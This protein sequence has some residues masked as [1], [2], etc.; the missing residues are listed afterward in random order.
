MLSISSKSKYGIM[1]VLTLADHY[2]QGLMQIK[3]ISSLNNIPHQYLIQ[4]FNILGKADI[5]KSVRGKNGGY[6]LSRNPAD[7]SVLEIVELL[8]GEI[9][10]IQNN[11]LTS[12]VH[13]LLHQAELS[14]K[15]VLNV[16]FADLLSSQHAIDRVPMFDI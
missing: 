5:I 10:F 15:K 13:E 11:P 7:I 4:I 8:E 2:R 6:I 3:E 1:A 9:V 16:S 14:L 12:A